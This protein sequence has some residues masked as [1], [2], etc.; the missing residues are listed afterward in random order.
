MYRA[1][2]LGERPL[3][4]TAPPRM[5]SVEVARGR[6][7]YGFA[8]SGQAPCVLSCVMRGSPADFVGL[9]AGDQILAVNEI[10]LLDEELCFGTQ[11]EL[12]MAKGSGCT[13]R[14]GSTRAALHPPAPGGGS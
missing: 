1:G 13:H 9:R 7:G 6:A 8:L 3:L 5:R 12:Q 11:G 14:P 10:D 2:D 4:G